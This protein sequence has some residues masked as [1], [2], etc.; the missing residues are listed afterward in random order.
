M[1]AFSEIRKLFLEKQTYATQ[2][3][4]AV[5]LLISHFF[6]TNGVAEEYINQLDNDKVRLWM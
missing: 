6:Q 3:I 5:P 4:K 2:R 1:F